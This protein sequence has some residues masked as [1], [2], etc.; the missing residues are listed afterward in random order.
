MGDIGIRF[1]FFDG[2]KI[3]K[4]GV[5]TKK[6]FPALAGRQVPWVTVFFLR[7]TKEIQSIRFDP[8]NINTAGEWKDELEGKYAAQSMEEILLGRPDNVVSLRRRSRITLTDSQKEILRNRIDWD[9]GTGTWDSLTPK[10]KALL[11]STG[12]TFEQ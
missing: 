1:Y 8:A 11:W 12:R 2:D 5:D 6:R 10:E 3:M 4:V 9:F 7:S